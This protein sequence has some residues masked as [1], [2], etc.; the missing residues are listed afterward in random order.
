VT[1]YR[2]DLL[3]NASEMVT[4]LGDATVVSA[5]ADA[6][7]E[8]LPILG[9]LLK[10]FRGY[11]SLRDML[12][13][14]KLRTFLLAVREISP[15]ERVRFRARIESEPGLK[16]KTGE[17]LVSVIERLDEE[18]KA[19]VLARMF[20][21][22]M[23]ERIDLDDLRRFSHIL[24]RSTLRDLHALREFIRNDR[25]LTRAVYDVLES[26]GLVALRHPIVR[27]RDQHEHEGRIEFGDTSLPFRVP[28]PAALFIHIAFPEH[29]P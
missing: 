12:F 8:E 7:L 27:A 22:F 15:G 4:E 25:Q 16:K 10:I 17:H 13:E 21:A 5:L 6:P 9:T 3:A 26:V 23:E 29:T 18:E 11:H 1:D 2:S 19:P 14:K 24:D 20:V 28:P